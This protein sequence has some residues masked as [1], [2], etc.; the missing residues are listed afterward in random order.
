MQGYSRALVAE[1]MKYRRT[2]AVWLAIGIPTLLVGLAWIVL[3]QS[4]VADKSVD[5]KW[6]ALMGVTSQTW[7]MTCLPIGGAILIGMLWGFEHNSNQLKHI[8]AQPPSRHAIFWAKT[9]GIFTL[10]A[11]GTAILGVL[12]S[13]LALGLDMGPIRVEAVFGIPFRA[14]LGS[15]PALALISWVAQRF[16]SFALPLILGVV[17]LVVAGFAAQSDYWQFVPWAWSI[18]AAMGGDEIPDGQATALG[19]ATGFGALTLAG[20]WLQFARADTAN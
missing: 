8:L 5:V 10:I 4:D 6:R 1:I 14:L 9:T 7:V 16:T 17:G 18:V 20:S 13:L 3:T 15:V 12:A 2:M 11:L 19:L